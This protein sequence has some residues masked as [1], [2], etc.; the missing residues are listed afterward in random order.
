MKL[1]LEL[2][3]KILS[4]I[5]TDADGHE[6]LWI[7]AE[8]LDK[9]Y[10]QK[11]VD[12]HLKI[13]NDD[14]LINIEAQI[15]GVIG[16]IAVNRLTAEGHRVLEVMNSTAWNEIKNKVAA[17]GNEGLKQIPSLFIKMAIL[18]AT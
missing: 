8:K 5:E 9:N 1:D 2:T 11:Q 12:Y 3:K 10:T 13:L 15:Q 16:S 17:I 7:I 14:A 6:T 4:K 18:S